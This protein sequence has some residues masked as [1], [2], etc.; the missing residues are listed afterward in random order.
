MAVKHIFNPKN[1]TMIYRY[2]KCTPLK[3]N[4]ILNAFL[5]YG[6]KKKKSHYGCENEMKHENV[7]GFLRNYEGVFLL[8]LLFRCRDEHFSS[9][10]KCTLE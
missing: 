9:D 1:I 5:Y 7:Q 4:Y 10:V 6:K 8:L 3:C 2:L